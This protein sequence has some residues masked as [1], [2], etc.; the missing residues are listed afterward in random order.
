MRHRRARAHLSDLIDGTLA[1]A[2]EASLRAHLE[3]CRACRRE[4]RELETAERLLGELPASLLSHAWTPAGEA[5]LLALTRWSLPASS[6]PSLGWRWPAGG[7]LAGAA[8]LALALMMWIH[9]ATPLPSDPR[10]PSR[11]VVASHN[12]GPFL[13]PTP[14]TP[15]S[16]PYTWRW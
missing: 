9:P 6:A 4:L 15:A 1:P 16:L 5:R 12:P 8:A 14:E 2:L 11:V 13:A 10:M 7:V 3:D